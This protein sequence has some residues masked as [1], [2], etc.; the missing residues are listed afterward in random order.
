MIKSTSLILIGAGGHCKSCISLIT[1]TPQYSIYGIVDKDGSK[2]DRIL[3]HNVIGS[4]SEL[5]TLLRVNRHALVAV[6]QIKSP[7]LR[8]SI[9]NKS[10]DFGGIFPVIKSPLSYISSNS[11]LGEGTAVFHH[12]I[13]NSSA[14]IGRNCILNNKT[15]I[16]HDV[17]I[18]SH[19]HISTGAL[20]NGGVII[21][22]ECFVGSGAIL[23]ENGRKSR[24]PS[25]HGRSAGK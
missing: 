3:D 14:K 5:E 21:E 24:S 7:A 17:T 8:I 22:D 15:L 6:G 4:D 19:C 12:S 1:S 25:I 23:Y 9:F 16:E 13:V 20:I 2:I 11:E 18:G 10:K